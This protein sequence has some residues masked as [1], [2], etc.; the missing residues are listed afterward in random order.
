VGQK[1]LSI[2]VS[3]NAVR[4]VA[5]EAT[6]RKAAV[7]M[8]TTVN[9]P[10]GTAKADIW[11]LV[12]D[13]VPKDIDSVVVSSDGRAAST[14][15]LQFPF[16]DPR[17]VDA[18]V[19]FELEGLVPYDMERTGVTWTV[20]RVADGKTDILAA[21]QAKDSVRE[22]IDAMSAVGLEPRSVVLP[23]AG[24][25]ELVTDSTTPVAVIAVGETTSHLAVVHRGLQFA[26]TMRVGLAGQDLRNLPML[27]R[28]ITTTLHTL[29]PDAQ[30]QRIFL[31]GGGSRVFGLVDA[32][33]EKVGVSV[34][35]LDIALGMAPV[36]IGEHVIPPEYAIAAGLAV[37][38]LRRGRHIPLNFRRADLA[39]HGDMQVYRGELVRVAVGI[40]AVVVL[41]LIGAIVQ[42]TMV[43]AED[44]Q[45]TQGFCDASR[46][47]I[48]REVCDPNAVMAIMRQSPGAGDGVVVPSYSASSLL[49]MMSQ[50]LEGVDT[51][52]TEL[53]IRVDGRADQPDKVTGKGDAA[54]FEIVE[55]VA[56][57][58]RQDRCV[59][60]VDISRQKKIDNGRVEFAIAVQAQCPLGVLPGQGAPTPTASAQE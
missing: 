56:S 11:P 22:L 7:T 6:F 3:R 57:R 24:L 58:L 45:L 16:V 20:S 41:A 26:R 10:E 15:A 35:L 5:L 29:A 55:E 40:A 38:T 18:A 52:F 13:Y 59:K 31:T 27:A 2:D 37:G 46:K 36:E 28:E 42:Y 33:A 25:A 14:R 12:R 4:L 43:S 48:G 44:R 39:Y 17:K 8:V 32:L 34:A 51:Q 53:E 30:P 54:S 50:S 1:T 23:A 9:I 21:M 60:D 47:I 49:A 19:E